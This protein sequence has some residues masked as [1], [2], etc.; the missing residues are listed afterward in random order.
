M[1]HA[2]WIRLAFDRHPKHVTDGPVKR[3]QPPPVQ[4]IGLGTGMKPGSKEDF[5]AVDISD[6][7]QK[8]LIHQ[9]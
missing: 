7:G 4:A 3:R 5:V 9:R 6:T 2:R 1:R 8:M